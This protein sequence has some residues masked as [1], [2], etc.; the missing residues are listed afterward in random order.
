MK[1]KDEAENTVS[2]DLGEAID[3][4]DDGT[5]KIKISK[6]TVKQANGN[7][8]NVNSDKEPISFPAE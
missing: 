5:G 7:V 8:I 3:K 2:L 6:V 1:K 4:L